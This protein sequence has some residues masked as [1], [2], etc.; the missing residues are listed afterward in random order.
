MHV[1]HE[2]WIP[3]AYEQAQLGLREAREGNT[4]PLDD[5]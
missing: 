4:I 5:L 2:M 1:L 3:G